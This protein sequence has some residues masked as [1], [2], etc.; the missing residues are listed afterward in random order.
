MVESVKMIKRVIFILADTL[1]AKHVGLYGKNPSPTP[2]IDRLG[3][4]GVVFTNTYCS[5]TCTD[6]S[7]TSIMAGKYPLSVQLVNHGRYVTLDEEEQVAKVPLLPEILKSHRYKTAAIDWLG[8]WHKRGYDYY[9]GRINKDFD[10]EYPIFDRLPFPLFI[11]AFD[12]LL[13]KN[14][15]RVFLTRW[16]YSFLANPKIPYDTA[17]III[18]KAVEILEKSRQKPFF[19]YL[20]FWDIHTPHI[21]PRGL[22]S[23]L[24]DSVEQTYTAEIKF[25]DGEIGRLVAY[26]DKTNQIDDTLIVLTADHGEN[27]FEHD[28]PLHHENLYEDVVR[29]PLF[30]YYHPL[31]R[32][33]VDTLVQQ[34]DIMPTV[35]AILGFPIPANIDGKSL[36]PLIRSTKKKIRDFAYFEDITYRRL[37]F[38]R[39]TRRRGIRIGQHKYIETLSGANGELYQI[40]PREDLFHVKE[41]LYNLQTDSLER[42]NIIREKT[43]IAKKLREKL[44]GKI[45]ELNRKRLRN[46]PDLN[47]KV[48]RSLQV[49]RKA[50]KRFKGKEI[51][52]AWTGG[53]DSTALLHL[54]RLAFDG[55]IPFKVIFND[56]TM[57]FEEIYRFIEKISRLWGIKVITIKHSDKEL[58]EF[59]NTRDREKK[60]ELS[61]IMKITAI[62]SALKKY[63]LKGFMAGIRWDEH[64][65]R[66]KE[67]YFSPRSDHIR[68][69]PLLHFTESD[70]WEYIKFFGVPFVDLY[71]KGYRSLGEKPFTH[72]AAPGQGERSGRERDKEQ[73]MQRLRKMGYW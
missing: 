69:H 22:R 16:Y 25:L 23:Y 18:D 38:M 46:N 52:L 73:L 28:M 17:N 60:K 36:L 24:F 21:R 55:K 31:G 1:R 32:K 53:K 49:I 45:L 40:T 8:R 61:R 50:V 65:S 41:E 34:V 7:I 62:N 43:Y 48:E 35:L 57:E 68:I 58:A 42:K 4:K 47:K 44:H 54:A 5:S 33:R 2:N 3:K 63:K 29:V 27:F 11:R 10:E 12:K 6:P 51:A 30:F 19:L 15:N 67:K 64:E 59:H 66:S 72:K 37:R 9:S 14:F 20:H 56:S 13:V 26:L 70:I 39:N 71:S